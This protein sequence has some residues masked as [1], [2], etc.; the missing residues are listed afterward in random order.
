MYVVCVFV[1][2]YMKLVYN[3]FVYVYFV[4]V[5]ARACIFAME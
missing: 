5:S 3:K 2:T 4:C 1:R